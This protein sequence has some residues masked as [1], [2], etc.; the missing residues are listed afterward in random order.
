MGHGAIFLL[1]LVPRRFIDKPL[2]YYNIIAF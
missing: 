2:A 1:I